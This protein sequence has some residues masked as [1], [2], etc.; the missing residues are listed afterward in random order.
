[1]TTRTAPRPVLKMC[2][3]WLDMC[4]L[5]AL[6]YVEDVTDD[7]VQ[8]TIRERVRPEWSS[9]SVMAKEILVLHALNTS[10]ALGPALF[11]HDDPVVLAGGEAHATFRT[12]LAVLC[13]E[14]LLTKRTDE[15]FTTEVYNLYTGLHSK[16]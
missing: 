2:G 4:A 1:M 10:E 11:E 5:V 8:E 13:E 16:D 14:H 9:L 7:H 15:E 3:R 6:H 12:A